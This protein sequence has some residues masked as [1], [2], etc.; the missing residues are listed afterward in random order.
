M[1]WLLLIPFFVSFP[2]HKN[3]E[4]ISRKSGVKVSIDG[5]LNEWRNCPSTTIR[6]EFRKKSNNKLSIQT[7][8]D[9]QYLYMAFTVTDS[10][11]R[12]KQTVLDHPE[13]YLDDIVEFL[14]DTKNDKDSCWDRDDIVYH[15]NL[16]GQKK[17]DRG[18][19]DCKTNTAWNGSAKFEVSLNGTLNDS[20]DADVGY[21]VEVAISWKELGRKPAAGVRVGLN[22]ANGDNG[23][24]FDWVG[25]SPFRS[26]FKFGDLVLK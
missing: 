20:T 19:D 7:M 14:L 11:L 22:F 15:I 2:L 3:K 8:W 26:P 25:A 9:K 12:A 24:L 13:L 4:L 23:K 10:N 1:Y 16:L 6:D 21:T 5:T 17:D 18:G